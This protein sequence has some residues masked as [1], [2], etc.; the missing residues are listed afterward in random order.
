MKNLKEVYWKVFSGY[1]VFGCG[2]RALKEAM[3]EALESAFAG[4]TQKPHFA[5]EW[6][7]I[8]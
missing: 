5:V 2:D 8:D 3:E 6:S 4:F 1:L 7:N